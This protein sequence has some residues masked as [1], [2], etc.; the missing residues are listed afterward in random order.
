MTAPNPAAASL[1]PAVALRGPEMVMRL[2]RMGAFF[3]TRLSFMC[4]LIRR[5]HVEGAVVRRTLWE[6]DDDGYGRA[7]YS[8]PLGGQDYSLV[9][10]ST[11]LTPDQRTDRVI[12]EA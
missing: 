10:F 9:A 8:V 11:P 1:V 7:V 6:I 3:A 2:S 12:A 5:L 4:S